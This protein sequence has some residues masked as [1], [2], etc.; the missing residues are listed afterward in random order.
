MYE[1]YR[2]ARDMFYCNTR[3][4]MF[5]MFINQKS[6]LKKLG[7]I[8]SHFSWTLQEH[9]EHVLLEHYVN[10]AINIIKEKV[11]LRS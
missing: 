5:Q 9:Y 2:N 11:T 7:H 10:D 8:N 3:S 4:M 6:Y 1:N